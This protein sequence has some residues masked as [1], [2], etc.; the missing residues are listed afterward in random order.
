M[1]DVEM[2]KLCAQAMGYR[3]VEEHD[4]YRVIAD[5]VYLLHGNPV[6]GYNLYDYQPVVDDAQAMALVKR[7]ELQILPPGNSPSSKK[8]NWYVWCG[9]N[10]AFDTDLNHAI[11][12]CVANTYQNEYRFSA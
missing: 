10:L 7:L 5:R 1:T 12:E 11:C 6:S 9:R 3:E 2:T 8:K 4:G